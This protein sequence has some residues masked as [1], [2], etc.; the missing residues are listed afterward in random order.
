M[1]VDTENFITATF[2]L[3]AGDFDHAEA[4]LKPYANAPSL[5]GAVASPDDLIRRTG[6]LRLRQLRY[7]KREFRELAREH[8][9]QTPIQA[10]PAVLE[11]KHMR[12]ALWRLA[13]REFD[14]R[15]Y[16]TDLSW[17]EKMLHL[18]HNEAA[19]HERFEERIA[20]SDYTLKFLGDRESRTS[21]GVTWTVTG[22][23]LLLAQLSDLCLLD[24]NGIWTQPDLPK[25]E[26]EIKEPFLLLLKALDPD[27]IP[28]VGETIRQLQ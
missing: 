17:E 13:A 11:T 6:A 23:M 1:P 14:L 22:S 18:A 8:G 27:S 4:L 12:G 2:A 9:L 7:K 20:H 19:L 3:W 16:L 25:T 24:V 21:L 10:T 5:D 15:A 28:V 26:H